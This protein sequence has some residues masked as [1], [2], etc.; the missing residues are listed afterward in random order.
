MNRI[1]GQLVHW[2]LTRSKMMKLISD[3]DESIPSVCHV[4]RFNLGSRSIATHPM[5][6]FI[7]ILS[8]LLPS[9]AQAEVQVTKYRVLGLFQPDRVDDLEQLFAETVTD[10]KLLNVDYDRA[11]ATFEFDGEKLFVTKK[12]EQVLERFD[13]LVRQASSGTFS[14][15]P[16]STVS[17]EKLTRIEITIA[18]LDCKAC[19]LAAYEAVAKLD[20]VERATASFHDRRLV[21][22]IDESKTNRDKL[23]EE[24]K[25]K[26]VDVPT[27]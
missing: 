24:L 21:A 9:V 7:M 8:L 3:V 1:M 13:N 14:V 12:P 26:R 22:W 6:L 17:P 11:E 19:S 20:G 23:I 10:V 4:K 18:G 2:V 15:R 25:K 27:P 5:I 16:L